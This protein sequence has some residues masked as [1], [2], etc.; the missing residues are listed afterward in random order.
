MELLI[1]LA[2]TFAVLLAA[3]S[4]VALLARLGGS[5]PDWRRMGA[6]AVGLTAAQALQLQ[7]PLS[8]SG[9]AL[10]LGVCVASCVLLA[11]LIGRTKGRET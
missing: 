4:A 11:Q 9:H 8:T 2:E 7:W 3:T 1:T 6:I 10:V 5:K